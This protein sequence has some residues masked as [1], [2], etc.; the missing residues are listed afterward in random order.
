MGLFVVFEVIGIIGMVQGFGSAVVTQ[1]WGGDW[2]LMQ[3]ALEWQPAGGIVVG[4]L[5][6]ALASVGWSGQKRI[7]ASRRSR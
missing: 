4:V 1:V 5:G 7:K 6:L 3:W 2:A